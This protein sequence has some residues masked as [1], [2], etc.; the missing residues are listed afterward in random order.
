[1]QAVDQAIRCIPEITCNSAFQ[2]PVALETLMSQISPLISNWASKQCSTALVAQNPSQTPATKQSQSIEL[3]PLPILQRT[4]PRNSY[5]I[6]PSCAIG[7]SE[8]LSPG[9]Q[10]RSMGA[11]DSMR[12]QDHELATPTKANPIVLDLETRQ[13]RSSPQ[14]QPAHHNLI[15]LTQPIRRP[16]QSLPTQQCAKQ[17]STRMLGPNLPKLTRS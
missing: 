17:T 4:P 11:S 13:A 7:R 14:G 1:M 8:D 2:N 6:T 5:S 3:E 10:V 16:N 9:P 12:G 15:S